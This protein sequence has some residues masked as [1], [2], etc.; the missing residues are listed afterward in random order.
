MT[1]GGQSSRIPD[2]TPSPEFNYLIEEYWELKCGDID[3]RIHRNDLR[4][5]L[6]DRN[7][8]GII[9]KMDRAF[10]AALAKER[11]AA[12]RKKAT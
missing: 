11:V 9:I 10:L 4:D 6:L 5:T 1:R 3:Y 12:S 2:Y 7:E 8:R